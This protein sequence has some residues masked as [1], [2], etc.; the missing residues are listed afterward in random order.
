MSAQT[1][2][3]TKTDDEVSQSSLLQRGATAP[4]FTLNSGP[5]KK[6]SLSDYRGK[7]VILAFYPADFSPVCGDQ[8]A[9][10]NE[11]L[12]EFQ[13]LNAQLLG[14]SV[15]SVWS[16]QAYAKSSNLHF[17]IL[18]DFHPK[19]AAGRLYGAYDE[20]VGEEH[21]SLF[22][23]DASGIVRWS[24]LAK[25]WVNPGANGILKALRTLP[26]QDNGGKSE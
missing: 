5:D 8:L 21:R 9:L 12:P 13:Q 23:I 7:N 10:Y 26:E 25:T 4:D 1:T 2:E 18:S 17:P 11:I 24:Y 22:V 19:G 15:D 14:I 20:S 16:H 3:S 6:V